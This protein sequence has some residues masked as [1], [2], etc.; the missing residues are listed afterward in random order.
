MPPHEG[1]PFATLFP[2]ASE[3]A[4]DLISKMLK[5]D[6]LER[7]TA[8]EAL[9]HPYLKEYHEYFEED[10]PPKTERFDQSF[11]DSALEEVEL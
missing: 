10:F 5:F 4:K 6:P 3:A 2:T 8:E 11:E 1:T 7:I 9:T